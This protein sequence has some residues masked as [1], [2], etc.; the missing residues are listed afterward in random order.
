VAAATPKAFY[1]IGGAELTGTPGPPPGRR[2]LA[3][4]YR[5]SEA[6]SWEKLASLPINSQAGYA[7]AD[8]EGGVLVFGGNDGALADRE[9]EVKD[10]HPGFSRAV[11]R[12]HNGKWTREGEMP[13]SLVTSGIVQWGGEFVIAGGEDRPAHR[14]SRVIA[15]SRIKK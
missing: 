2:F 1:L 5:Y 7:I 3:D 10:N 11:F 12:F 13:A 9:F 8:N 15:A 4:T 14:S 6:K